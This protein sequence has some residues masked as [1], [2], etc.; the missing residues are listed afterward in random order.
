LEMRGPELWTSALGHDVRFGHPID[1]ADKG[2]TLRAMLG[3]ELPVA[4]LIDITSPLRPAVVPAESLSE[5]ES[6][7]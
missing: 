5:V 3:E 4:A 6:E 1:L 2:R 7:G